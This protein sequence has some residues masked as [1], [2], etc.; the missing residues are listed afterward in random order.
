[1]R[2]FKNVKTGII[3]NVTNEKLVEQYTKRKDIW[4]EVKVKEAKRE[5]AKENTP[6]DNTDS[7]NK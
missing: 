5:G 1:M 2:K 3:E 4:Q 6:K 7:E